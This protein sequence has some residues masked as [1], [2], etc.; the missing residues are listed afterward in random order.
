MYLYLTMDL[1]LEESK[2]GDLNAFLDLIGGREPLMKSYMPEV[3][4]L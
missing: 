1:S 4:P 2:L 3:K